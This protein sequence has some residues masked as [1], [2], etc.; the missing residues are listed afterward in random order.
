[1][2]KNDIDKIYTYVALAVGLLLWFI[3]F[4]QGHYSFFTSNY[5]RTEFSH[6]FRSDFR[7]DFIRTKFSWLLFQF[8]FLYS[9]WSLRSCIVA[10]FK[11]IHNKI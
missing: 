3:Y 2:K 11:K 4:Y 6:F 7:V 9:W 5:R 10:M 1:M 8:L